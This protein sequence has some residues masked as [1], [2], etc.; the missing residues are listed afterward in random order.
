MLG[1]VMELLQSIKDSARGNNAIAVSLDAV[2]QN[3]K[4]TKNSKLET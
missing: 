2:N 4:T 1:K 3:A